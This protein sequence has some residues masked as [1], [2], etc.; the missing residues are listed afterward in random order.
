MG[1]VGWGGFYNLFHVQPNYCVEVVLQCVVVGVVTISFKGVGSV[2]LNSSKNNSKKFQGVFHESTYCCISV[3][4]AYRTEGLVY[5]DPK[6][7]ERRIFLNK[8]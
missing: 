8:H 3:I 4:T 2:F 1:G 6:S 7:F 5:F